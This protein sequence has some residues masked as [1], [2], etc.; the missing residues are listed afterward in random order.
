MV[1][2]AWDAFEDW[3]DDA[4]EIV[5]PHEKAA[6]RE[7]LDTKERLNIALDNKKEADAT[8]NIEICEKSGEAASI[9]AQLRRKGLE[10]STREEL[11]V[12]LTLLETFIN[13]QR[14]K[15]KK[16]K[17]EVKKIQLDHAEAKKKLIAYREERGKP[18]AS[19]AVE[20]EMHLEKYNASH[21]AYHG[22]D[23]NGVSCQRI[24]GNST[25]IASGIK[26]I[27]ESKRDERCDQATIDK[28]VNELEHTLG[29][30]DAAFIY[31]NI[32]HPS[33]EEKK[34]QAKLSMLYQSI[35]GALG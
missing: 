30:L 20:I 16:F 33:D 5:P 6:H 13:E 15:I 29:L 8:I 21:A 3:V 18:E 27:L 23:Y 28:K 14:N 9:K 17:E 10:N 34:K 2:Q 11:K 24:V 25:E 12:Q 31:L 7:V 22:G 35:G 26:T 4:V 1:N 19:I 32:P